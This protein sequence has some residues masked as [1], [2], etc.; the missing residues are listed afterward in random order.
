MNFEQSIRIK[1]TPKKVWYDEEIIE[2]FPYERYKLKLTEKNLGKSA[3]FSEFR[4]FRNRK[5]C[6]TQPK[7]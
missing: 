3:M 4:I 5:W 6:S 2:F 7:Y 1:S